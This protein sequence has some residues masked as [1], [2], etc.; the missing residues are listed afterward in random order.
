MTLQAAGIDELLPLSGPISLPAG[1][2]AAIA[3]RPEKLRLL[4][5]RPQGF[6]L[7]AT[8]V[9]VGY[10]GGQSTVHLTTASGR[11]LRAHLPSEAALGLARGTA[12]WASW[13]P[14]DAV[15]LTE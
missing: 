2:T 15:V 3:V 1:A 6:A 4:S 7:A 8:T 11:M 10:Q 13:S 12:V 14:Q 5:A 9:S